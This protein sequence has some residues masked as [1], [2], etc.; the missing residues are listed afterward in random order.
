MEHN[1]P[2]NYDPKSFEDRIYKSWEESGAFRP[3]KPGKPHFSIVMPPPNITGQLHM[4]HALDQSL[5][6]VLTRFKR[7]QGYDTLWLPGTDHA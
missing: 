7:M 1:L 3:D 4:G 6:D 2:K 5:Q